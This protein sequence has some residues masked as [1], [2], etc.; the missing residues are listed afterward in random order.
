MG[1]IMKSL[2]GHR[3]VLKVLYQRPESTQCDVRRE[4][5]KD[6]G[7]DVTLT[8]ARR[9]QEQFD[10]MIEHGLIRRVGDGD[11]WSITLKGRCMLGTG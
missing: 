7:P 6:K 5:D 10:D 9:L 2:T 8:S 1:L 11:R 3:R 4:I